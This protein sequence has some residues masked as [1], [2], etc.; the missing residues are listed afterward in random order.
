MA[1]AC[2]QTFARRYSRAIFA[3]QF[4][5]D[6]AKERGGSGM[7]NRERDIMTL[8]EGCGG[9]WEA[10]KKLIWHGLFSS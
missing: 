4:L 3:S 5:R 1:M 10:A 6:S 7:D 8:R 2:S 9:K